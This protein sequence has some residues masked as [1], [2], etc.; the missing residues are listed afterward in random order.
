MFASWKNIKPRILAKLFRRLLML[1]YL[2]LKNL[3]FEK[4]ILRIFV[5]QQFFFVIIIVIS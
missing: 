3:F 5:I 2:P 4:D 1:E